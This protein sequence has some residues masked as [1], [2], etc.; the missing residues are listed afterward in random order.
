MSGQRV[1]V[2]GLRLASHRNQTARGETMMFM[3]LEDLEGLLDVVFFPDVYRRVSATLSGSQPFLVT[4]MLEYD[5]ERGEPLLRA[6][7]VERLIR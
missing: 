3:T 4:G 6:E 5:F 2:A 1:K 7:R